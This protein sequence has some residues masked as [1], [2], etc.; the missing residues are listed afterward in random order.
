MNDAEIIEKMRI[1]L[2][3]TKCC[4]TCTDPVAMLDELIQEW[5]RLDKLSRKDG[6]SV[7]EEIISLQKEG[8]LSFTPFEKDLSDKMTKLLEKHKQI[9]NQQNNK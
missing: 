9:T 5:W 3:G 7:C 2:M 8:T 1:A 4:N 6:C